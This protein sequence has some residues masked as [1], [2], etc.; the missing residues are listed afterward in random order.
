MVG[1]GYFP[2]GVG[3]AV[4]VGVGATES[5]A[6]MGRLAGR[7]NLEVAC[8]GRVVA[9]LEFEGKLLEAGIDSHAWPE[10]WSHGWGFDDTFGGLD[11]ESSCAHGLPGV[12]HRL[13]RMSLGA[14]SGGRVGLEVAGLVAGWLGQKLLVN[15]VGLGLGWTEIWRC[16][17]AFWSFWW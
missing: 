11:H 12:S 16:H 7:G 1:A 14:G 8:P 3:L 6:M 4:M 10:G 17:L 13:P 5:W 2:G 9:S 15:S